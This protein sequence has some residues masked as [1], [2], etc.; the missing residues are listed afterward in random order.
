M[1]GARGSTVAVLALPDDG[2]ADPFLISPLDY[3]RRCLD[4]LSYTLDQVIQF[5]GG[6]NVDGSSGRR[7]DCYYVIN[8]VKIECSLYSRV[9]KVDYTE[10]SEWCDFFLKYAH[11]PV[12]DDLTSG[13]SYGEDDCLELIRKVILFLEHMLQALGPTNLRKVISVTISSV[14]NIAESVQDLKVFMERRKFNLDTYREKSGKYLQQVIDVLDKNQENKQ[15]KQL[16]LEVVGPRLNFS[17]DE[18]IENTVATSQLKVTSPEGEPKIKQPSTFETKIKQPSNVE[19]KRVDRDIIRSNSLVVSHTLKP[20]VKLKPTKIPFRRESP[21]SP[22]SSP[23]PSPSVK[24]KFTPTHT[25]STLLQPP[26]EKVKQTVVK[27]KPEGQATSGANVPSHSRVKASLQQW[28]AIIEQNTTNTKT[29]PKLQP[30]SKLQERVQLP[31]DGS[32]TWPRLKPTTAEKPPVKSKPS[33]LNSRSAS[34]PVIKPLLK[35]KPRHNSVTGVNSK[36][37]VMPQESAG[38]VK[39]KP[40][41]KPKPQRITSTS[42]ESQPTIDAKSDVKEKLTSPKALFTDT[43]TQPQ[44]NSWNV[45]PKPEIK[46]KPQRITSTSSESQPTTDAKSDVKEKLTSPKALFTD[47]G[48]QPRLVHRYFNLIT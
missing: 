10:L 5:C 35:P 23:K 43:G 33:Y 34:Q 46:P 13:G 26:E 25:K 2:T 45:K 21:Y 6:Y 36:P 3:H 4:L 27:S 19:P 22:L 15:V 37:E 40:E 1:A 41:I 9:F 11:G 47:T 31:S 7:K 14:N 24:P 38:N 42:S 39:P 18:G 16:L 32:K 28:N 29:P 44:A 12:E 20:E 48:T 17:V 8:Y 30:M